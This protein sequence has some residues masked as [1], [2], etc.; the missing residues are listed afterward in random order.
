MTL[1]AEIIKENIQTVK[2]AVADA[3]RVSRR[4]ADDIRIMAVTKA[5][6]CDVV[7]L[8]IDAGITLFGEN[9]VQEAIDKF[10]IPDQRSYELH[11]IG[12]LQKN[13]INKSLTFFSMIQSV[14]SIS[15]AE[16]VNKRAAILGIVVP[17]LLEFNIGEERTKTGFLPRETVFLPQA[18]SSLHNLDVQGMMCIPPYI[19]NV[20]E[21]RPY[22]AAMRSLFEMLGDREPFL[23]HFKVLSMGMS[24]DYK[25]AIEEGATMVRIGTAFFGQRR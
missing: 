14:D 22:F 5:Q 11:M 20:N 13:K 2:S 24:H 23:N 6:P 16:E 25:I 7:R 8:A 15:L 12:A 9:K 18:F 3:A 21:V 19:E 10:P 1:S 4:Q 17:V